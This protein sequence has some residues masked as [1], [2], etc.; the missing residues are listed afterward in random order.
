MTAIAA[1]GPSPLWYFSRGA[2]LATLLLLTLSVVLGIGTAASSG[3]VNG[4]R[5]VTASLHRT[6]SLLAVLVLAAHI[7]TAVLDPF[8]HLTAR[9]ALVPFG[10]AYRPVWLGLGVVAAEILGALVVTSLL[11]G[12]IGPRTWRAI[13]WSAYA[14]WPLA[15]VHGLGTGSDA[16]A[17]W[18]LGLTAACATAVVLA[19][20]R[21]LLSGR[22]RTAPVRLAATAAATVS[23]ASIAGWTARGPLQ[24]N[25]TAMSG[26]PVAVVATPRP[27]PVHPP[28]RGF[29][30][31]LIGLMAR[32]PAGVSIGLRDL[33][34]TQLVLSLRPPDAGETLPVLTVA[35]AG[36]TLCTTPARPE[37]SF[38]A[39][40]GATRLTITLA[41]TTGDRLTGTLATSGPLG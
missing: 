36:H 6:A 34:D 1:A 31:G 30:D 16:Q 24:P 29:S 41:A 9:D 28:G 8:A 35:R 23:L 22:L 20:L 25:W 38:Y 2:G 13:H 3:P 33:V 26:T 37:R 4:R 21:R 14:S 12:R 27:T 7:T 15:V 18:V 19:G 39:V 5:F 17:P 11:R 40:C 32:G 10:A